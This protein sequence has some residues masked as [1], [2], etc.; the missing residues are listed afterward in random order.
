MGDL[1]QRWRDLGEVRM[2]TSLNIPQP[3][4]SAKKIPKRGREESDMTEMTK[5][6][7]FSE[8]SH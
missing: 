3:I 4:L 1:D 8:P 6:Q 2:K 7:K 5:Q